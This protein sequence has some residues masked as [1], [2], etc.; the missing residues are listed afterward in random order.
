MIVSHGEN[1]D[2]THDD[3]VVLHEQ[4]AVAVYTNPRNEVVIRQ[5]CAWDEDDDTVIFVLPE[6]AKA[7]ADAIMAAAARLQPPSASPPSQPLTGAERQK[8][9][10]ERNGGRDA[11]SDDGDDV[12]HAGVG[13]RLPLLIE[14]DAGDV[15]GRR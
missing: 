11:T 5:A 9:Y 12:R 1:F 3:A 2:W 8:R 10:R 6:N 4:P 7:V 13:P 14:S 15:T